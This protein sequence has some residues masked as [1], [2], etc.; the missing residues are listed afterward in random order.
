MT[1]AGACQGNPSP[2]ARRRG[3]FHQ[4]AQHTPRARRLA[5]A[6]QHATRPQGSRLR[7]MAMEL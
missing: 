5:R 6:K 4:T 1:A 3:W 7:P 2:T